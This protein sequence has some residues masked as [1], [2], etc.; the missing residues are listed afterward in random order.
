MASCT[1][2]QASKHSERERDMLV[3]GEDCSTDS[4]IMRARIASG[5]EQH[6]IYLTNRILRIA[7]S[8]AAKFRAPQTCWM[9]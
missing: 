8:Y 4:E 2:L 7:H 6:I 3:P 5:S 9:S 1:L